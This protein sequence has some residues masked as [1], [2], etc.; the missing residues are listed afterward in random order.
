MKICKAY[1]YS[2]YCPGCK[3]AHTV[4][5]GWGYNG[6]EEKPTFSDHSIAVDFRPDGPFCHSY[7]RNGMIEFLGD[8][9]HELAGQT[10]ELPHFPEGYGLN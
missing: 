5:K 4:N 8:S 2:F 10:V 6:D 7:I 9:T 3:M 1:T